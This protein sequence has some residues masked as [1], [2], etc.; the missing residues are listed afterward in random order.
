MSL[1][2][3]LLISVSVCMGVNGLGFHHPRN[4]THSHPTTVAKPTHVTAGKPSVNTP[5]TTKTY[6]PCICN[7]NH[8][9][10][11]IFQCP[12]RTSQ[13]IGFLYMQ[14]SPYSIDLSSSHC[15]DLAKFVISPNGWFPVTHGDKIG[16]IRRDAGTSI[17]MCPG[18][19]VSH[20]GFHP[21]PCQS[22][23]IFGESSTDVSKHPHTVPNTSTPKP[24][25]PPTTTTTTTTT[26]DTTTTIRDTTTAAATKDT[27]TTSTKGDHVCNSLE[28]V[29]ELGKHEPVYHAQ[30]RLCSGGDSKNEAVVMKFCYA[31]R[32]SNWIQGR[33]V[34][35]HCSDIPSYTPINMYAFGSNSMISGIFIM[36]TNTTEFTI[37]HQKDC[38]DGL[39]LETIDVQNGSG[40]FYVI[41]W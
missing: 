41:H 5:T 27:T 30:A 2:Q 3:V 39:H 7:K 17:E 22:F 10:L 34:L 13:L 38:V 20:I 12:N 31:P 19:D 14:P 15:K 23:L 6:H 37:I 1:L 26:R 28:V 24:T 32:A 35:D 36:C 29:L 18:P 8:P 40:M 21:E 9:Q 33:K 4:T 16:F 11:D 25:R